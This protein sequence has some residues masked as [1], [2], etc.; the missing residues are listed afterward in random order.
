MLEPQR[1]RPSALAASQRDT[2]EARRS[3]QRGREPNEKV[4]ETFPDFLFCGNRRGPVELYQHRAA[5]A[6]AIPTTVSSSM[7]EK[8]HSIGAEDISK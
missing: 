5:P 1:K 2:A 3:G 8:A 7:V 6:P 4:R